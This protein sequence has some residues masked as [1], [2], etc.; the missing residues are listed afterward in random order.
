MKLFRACLLLA[1]F[2]HAGDF[3]LDNEAG[4]LV[5]KSVELV[6]EVSSELFSKTGVSFVL[7]LADTPDTHTKQ[8]RLAYQ[9]AKLK[10][11]HRPFVALFAHFG[12]QKID[13]LSDPKDLIPTERIFFERI[14]P[15]L[16]KEWGTDTAKN[17]ARFSFALLNGYTYMADAIAHKYHIQLANN[18][19]EEYSNSVVKTTLYILLCSLL[20]LFFYGYFFGTR[21][22][23]H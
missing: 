15:F 2:L 14:A 6:Q 23:G 11:L 21:K 16:P 1:G 7:F 3:V 19:K 18:I 13:I 20:A 9:Q 4:H 10:D 5:P 8:G 12:A 22:H 17:N